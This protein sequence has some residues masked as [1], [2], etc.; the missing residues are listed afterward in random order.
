VWIGSLAVAACLVPSGAALSSTP[1]PHGHGVTATQIHHG[2]AMVVNHRG[3]GAVPARITPLA[4]S[5]SYLVYMR[6]EAR[7]R[8]TVPWV[9]PSKFPYLRTR[10]TL[11]ARSLNGT[12]KVLGPLKGHGVGGWSLAGDTL[13]ARQLN[14]QQ[15]RRTLLWWNVADGDT[16]RIQLRKGE[17]LVSAAPGGALVIRGKQLLELKTDGTYI[18]FHSPLPDA[19]QIGTVLAGPSG[20]VIGSSRADSLSYQTWAH[21]ETV[22]ALDTGLPDTLVAQPDCQGM[23]EQYVAC[24]TEDN[25]PDNFNKFPRLLRLD[26]GAPV[27]TVHDR[28]SVAGIAGSTLIYRPVA[29]TDHRE[30]LASVGAGGSTPSYSTTKITNSI[31][32]ALG[33]AIATPVDD[34]T[35]M[36][37]ATDASHVETFLGPLGSANQVGAFSLAADRIAWVDSHTGD[38]HVRAAVHS[39]SVSA[40][41]SSITL[42]KPREVTPQPDGVPRLSPLRLIV[43]NRR[44]TVVQ[45]RGFVG[46]FGRPSSVQVP[47]RLL[48]AD[49]HWIVTSNDRNLYLSTI[50]GTDRKMLTR[51]ARWHVALSGDHLAVLQAN[52]RVTA[53][54]LLTGHKVV[55]ASPKTHSRFVGG[56]LAIH[57][58][59][60]GWWWKFRHASQIRNY[61]TMTQS[62][63][64]HGYVYSLSHHGALAATHSADA[65]FGDY[66]QNGN[67]MRGAVS[68]VPHHGKPRELFSSRLWVQLPE[69]VGHAV[70]WA[71]DDGQLRVAALKATL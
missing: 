39:R 52:G 46:V 7:G 12:E 58:S 45:Q 2:P 14:S 8:G 5:P 24:T 57:G 64:V 67:L 31:I 61:R 26:G 27:V 47:G 16:G 38:S 53:S 42:G 32:T 17:Y 51:H 23:S 60:I 19:Q 28:G 33:M 40:S 49:A 71:G 37:G 55:V 36:V 35:R 62:R 54:N 50:D 25:N 41:P 20:V 59:W 48:A 18:S 3:P 13:T 22:I 21:P 66:Y 65:D 15:T 69:V 10:R 34:L 63:K 44:S 68:Y 30:Q 1:P 43:A 4:G 9:V 56:T 6:V 70:A 11:V 29:Y